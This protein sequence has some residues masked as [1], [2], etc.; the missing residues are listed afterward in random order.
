M[1]SEERRYRAAVN[2]AV[3]QADPDTKIITR[4]EPD[5]SSVLHRVI[6]SISTGLQHLEIRDF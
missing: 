3:R 2:E 4:A 6:R 1:R 5:V